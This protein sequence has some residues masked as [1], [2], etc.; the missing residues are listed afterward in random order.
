MTIAYWCLLAVIF[1]TYVY[2]GIAKFAQPG[3][4]NT[5]P[6]A[7]LENL[8]GWSKRAYWAHLNSLEVL[9]QFAA[10]LIIAHQLE[11]P[12]TYIDTAAV[13]FTVL[14]VFYGVFYM[15]N[16]SWYR[17]YC[18]LGGMFIIGYLIT[19]AWFHG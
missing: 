2:T 17:S 19:G 11:M 16:W 4:N 18:W 3:Y 1:L 10:A 15:L 13:V 6:R 12:Q 9:P 8:S 5:C 7:Y 14:R